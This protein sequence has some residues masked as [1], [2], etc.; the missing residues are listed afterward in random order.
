MS[1]ISRGTTEA[2]VPFPTRK[3]REVWKL[4]SGKGHAALV[5]HRLFSKA[6]SSRMLA[7]SMPG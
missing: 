3:M 2:T 4:W 1:G 7:R 6:Q 5:D